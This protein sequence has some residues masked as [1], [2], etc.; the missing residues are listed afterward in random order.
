MDRRVPDDPEA[1]RGASGRGCPDVGVP[2]AAPERLNGEQVKSG[3]RGGF[4]A[5]VA[6]CAVLAAYV[7]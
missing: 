2:A 7:G 3:G 1:A 4:A 5:G 6:L